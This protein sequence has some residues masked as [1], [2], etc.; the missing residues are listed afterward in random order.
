MKSLNNNRDQFNLGQKMVCKIKNKL[1]AIKMLSLF[2][3]ENTECS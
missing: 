1:Y 3:I 2:L